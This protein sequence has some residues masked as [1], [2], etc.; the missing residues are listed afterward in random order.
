MAFGTP[1]APQAAPQSS[2]PAPPTSLALPQSQNPSSYA[3][4][5]TISNNMTTQSHSQQQIYPRV[6]VPQY[7]TPAV[8][9]SKGQVQQPQQ[10]FV[11]Q[12]AP[13]PSY[14]TPSM[15]Q[16]VVG[17]SLKRRHVGGGSGIQK[18]SRRR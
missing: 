9:P 15:W 8:T 17:E 12:Q 6:Q 4:Y 3:T 16:E 14:V 13:Y 10:V 2:P 1:A 18:S 11:Q 7:Q 5:S